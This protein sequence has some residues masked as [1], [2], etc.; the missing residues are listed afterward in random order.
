M[1]SRR[2]HVRDLL[3]GCSSTDSPEAANPTALDTLGIA[4]D[5][6]A[7]WRTIHSATELLDADGD[8][9]MFD[10]LAGCAHPA[11]T[12]CTV[13]SGNVK[14]TC[15]PFVDH[16]RYCRELEVLQ[17]TSFQTLQEAE[18][19]YTFFNDRWDWKHRIGVHAFFFE[20]YPILR[21]AQATINSGFDVY[22]A[23]RAMDN[24]GPSGSRMDDVNLDDDDGRTDYDES[25]SSRE[26]RRNYR[27]YC[28][29]LY[30]PDDV[31]ADKNYALHYVDTR[32]PPPT[33]PVTF[34]SQILDPPRD[35]VQRLLEA[36]SVSASTP[37][38]VRRS[39]GKATSAS[40]TRGRRG[41]VRCISTG[42]L[43]TSRPAVLRRMAS[44]SHALQRRPV[45]QPEA[46]IATADTETDVRTLRHQ[47]ASKIPT[48]VE[49][50]DRGFPWIIFVCDNPVL[51]RRTDYIIRPSKRYCNVFRVD[52]PGD[53]TD[54]DDGVRW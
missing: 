18:E 51:E 13:C 15:D 2:R 8:G 36:N 39:T 10:M 47:R 43:S 54:D 45:S 25:D 33:Q 1:H 27:Q 49:T 53:D 4:N 40:G 41:H 52:T 14:A 46:A 24:G 38:R 5:E 28:A 9:E 7:T 44:T 3:L 17:R 23:C 12:T 29:W 11:V 32:L 30:M 50:F 34:M 35:F 6:K 20:H 48:L 16:A 21:N 37:L 19:C 26:F 31:D 22:V 42:S